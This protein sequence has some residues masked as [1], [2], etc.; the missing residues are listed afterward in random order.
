MLGAG[1]AISFVL[2]FQ[3]SYPLN[4]KARIRGPAGA[5]E[6]SLYFSLS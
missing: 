2:R 3:S 1:R 4:E 5:P 6:G